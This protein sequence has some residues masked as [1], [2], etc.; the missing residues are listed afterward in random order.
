MKKK[1]KGQKRGR[2]RKGKVPF[3]FAAELLILAILLAGASF[4]P[5]VI[6]FVQDSLLCDKTM[7]GTRENMDVESLSISYEKSLGLRM[8]DFAE[9]LSAG[10]K[11]YVASQDL[12]INYEV[13]EY[14]NSEYGIYQEF[15]I[16]FSEIGYFSLGLFGPDMEPHVNQWKQYVIYGDLYA[17][18][19]NFILWYIEVENMEGDIL[20]LL[21]DAETGTLYA[22]K[23]ERSLYQS[24]VVIT[25]SLWDIDVSVALWNFFSNYFEASVGEDNIDL[26]GE[27]TKKIQEKYLENKYSEY[28]MC[29]AEDEDTFEFFV[30]DNAGFHHEKDL[31]SFYL[32]YGEGSLEICLQLEYPFNEPNLDGYYSS[33]PN[34]TMGVRQIY[35]M[36]P[37]FA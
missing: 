4:A 8:G 36:I 18:G 13:Q 3:M 32:P 11:Y 14:V 37:E 23:L 6:F 17:K 35:E 1:Q 16:I 26:L 34:V 15:I 21:T 19:V 29:I 9:G 5:Q 24:G 2:K 27:F 7:L 25:N 12:D 10:K 20:K 30:R 31:S 33:L 22:V 28:E